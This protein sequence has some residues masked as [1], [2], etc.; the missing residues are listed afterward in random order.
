MGAVIIGIGVAVAAIGIVLGA[1]GFGSAETTSGAALFTVGSIVFVGGILLFGLGSIQR[2]VV[3]VANKLDG[4]LHYEPEEE[5]S[6]PSVA[7]FEERTVVASHDLDAET[8]SPVAPPPVMRLEPVASTRTAAVAA[9]PAFVAVESDPEPAVEAPEPAPVEEKAKPAG[10]GLPS[11]FR[12]KAEQPVVEPEPIETS[13]LEAALEPMP[14]EPEAEPE[15]EPEP[16]TSDRLRRDVP[17]FLR[18]GYGRSAAAEAPVEP[19]ARIEPL[20]PEPEPEAPSFLSAEDLLAE[21]EEEL[22]PPVLLKSGVIGGMA[23]KLYSDGAI[24]AD[25]PDGTLRFASL[26]ELRDHVAASAARTEG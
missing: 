13:V 4:V 20:A 5:A 7:A 17:S 16:L 21:P 11:W 25:L 22:P 8:A 26:Q 23:Y 24:E 3:D 2:A 1:I 12:R 19:R 9:E 15:P 10:R 14:P 6:A 18:E